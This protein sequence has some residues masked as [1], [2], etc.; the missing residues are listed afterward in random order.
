[1]DLRL[2]TLQSCI[3]YDKDKHI[4]NLWL[5]IRKV[6]YFIKDMIIQ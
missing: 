5:I 3:A 2:P 1:M 6:I 4:G